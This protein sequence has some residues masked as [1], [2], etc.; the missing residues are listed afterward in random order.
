MVT[1]NNSSS[2]II[3]IT[4]HMELTIPTGAMPSGFSTSDISVSRLANPP[5]LPDGCFGNCYDIRPSGIT[6]NT[7]V[8]ITIVHDADDCPNL[9]S[10]QVYWYNT[11]T[12]T[13]S[14]DGISE[15]EHYEITE[16]LH[17]VVCKTTHFTSF[18]VGASG[19]SN[20]GN[21]GDGGSD[22][23]GGGCAMSP[24]SQSSDGAMGYVLEYLVYLAILFTISRI[25]KRKRI[26]EVN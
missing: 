8:T 2:V 14:Q 17:A 15:V 3:Q 23:G 1:L 11:E 5:R 25:Y 6:F 9:N 18:V 16:D 24:Y 10:Y 7:P 4:G 26:N 12:D 13:W 21:V 22:S 19:N 20:P